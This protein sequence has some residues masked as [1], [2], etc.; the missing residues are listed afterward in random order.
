M[1]DDWAATSRDIHEITQLK[2]RYLRALDTK[3]WERFAACFVPE[4][5]GDYNGLTFDDRRRPG[6]LHAR[7]T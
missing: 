6:R 2:Y 7:P 3:D 5:T 1:T 4:A